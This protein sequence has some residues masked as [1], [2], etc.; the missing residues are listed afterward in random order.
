MHGVAWSATAI[1]THPD[2]VRQ[3]H[4]DYVRAGADIIIANTFATSR[5]ILERAG[6]GGKVRDLNARAVALAK[7]ARDAAS[8]GRAV[9]IAGS[10]ST[11]LMP[12]SGKRTSSSPPL[13]AAQARAHYREQADM[14][15]EAGVD[16][17]ML[18]MMINVEEAAHI[19][20]AAVATG[21]PTWIGYSCRLSDDG[22][23]V[24]LL[25]GEDQTLAGAM[26]ALMPLGGSLVSVMH[27]EVR[28][29]VPA[30]R[31]VQEH[32]DGPLGAYAHSG[33][34]AMPNWQFENIINPQDYL[35]EV[36]AWTSMGVQ[37][38]GGC[39]GIGPDHIRLMASELAGS[40]TDR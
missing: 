20:E 26:T 29:T 19:I 15:A 28:D 3:V 18:E 36:R 5:A 35:A 14:L 38:V 25:H 17:I 39:C 6:M 24:L 30:L 8:G 27:T 16:L 7:E 23:E 33:R 2:V 10:I 9:Y 34:F 1:E 21:L 32:W 22:S 40:V 31:V 11:S 4:E 13:S 12:A 37:L